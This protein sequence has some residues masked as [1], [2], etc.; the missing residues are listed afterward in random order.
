[1]KLSLAWIR[2]SLILLPVFFTIYITNIV[3]Y[4]LYIF[5][6][7]ILLFWVRLRE[8]WIKLRLQPLFFLMEIAV[9]A[10]MISDYH[11]ILYI[12]FCS[13]LISLFDLPDIRARNIW[14]LLEFI[15]MNYALSNEAFS[16]LILANVLFAIVA[17][18]LLYAQKMFVRKEELQSLYDELKRKHYELD[19]ARNRLMDYAKLVESSTQIEERNRISRDIHDDLGHKLIRLKM[20]MEAVIQILPN[21][22]EKGMEM[23]YQV[24][25]QLTESMETLRQTVRNMKPED[26]ITHSFS[27]EKLVEGLNHDKHIDVLYTIFGMPY[28]LYPSCEIVLY[29]NSQEAITNA[30]RHGHATQVTITL[31]YERKQIILKVSNNGSIPLKIEKNGIGISGMEERTRLLGGRLQLDYSDPFTLTT[32][33]PILIN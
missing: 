7:L 31:H 11:G 23:I 24:R 15:L 18:L 8:Q 13:S 28:P 3:S 2:Y 33:I 16:S 6:A 4:D 17:F 25:D 5:A 14:I 19:E 29:R 12:A 22:Q 27:L 9:I 1:V 26:H 20:M 30:I 21:Q 10:W 32:F